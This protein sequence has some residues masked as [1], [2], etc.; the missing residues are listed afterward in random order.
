MITLLLLLPLSHVM[1]QDPHDD[2]SPPMLVFSQVVSLDQADDH[3]DNSDGVL[4]N[5]LEDEIAVAR[6]QASCALSWSH[7]TCL[8]SRDCKHCHQVDIE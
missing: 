1:C 6:C 7:E 4:E 5:V 3:P 8:K 2:S